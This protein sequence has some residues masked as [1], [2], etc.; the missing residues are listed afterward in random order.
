MAGLAESVF[1]TYGGMSFK[2][3]EIFNR[4]LLAKQAWK[5]IQFPHS[6]LARV[7]RYKYC[8]SKFFFAGEDW[9]KSLVYVAIDSVWT[10]AVN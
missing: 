2:N 6:L 10:E 9:S 8:R 5:I 1:A 4:A 7:L 3:M